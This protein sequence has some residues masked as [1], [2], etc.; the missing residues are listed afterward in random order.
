M[1]NT[2]TSYGP[3][4]KLF[5]WV[6]GVSIITLIAVGL[7]MTDMKDSPLKW[8][9]FNIHKATGVVVFV[10]AAMR[11]LWLL[12]SPVPEFINKT[13]PMLNYAAKAVHYTMYLMM[14][15]SPISG[16]IMS[17]FSGHAISMYGLYTIEPIYKVH[18]FAQ[19]ALDTHIFLGWFWIAVLTLHISAALYHHFFLKDRTLVRMLPGNYK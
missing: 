17:L 9:I 5:H 7:Y 6:I 10:L 2:K 1:R 11:F 4:T 16:I 8:E 13:T 15:G 12:I 18:P 3:I 14:F 19:Y